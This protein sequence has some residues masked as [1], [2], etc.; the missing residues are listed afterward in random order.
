MIF[1]TKFFFE[2]LKKYE[3]NEKEWNWR[4]VKR[5]RGTGKG[6]KEMGLQEWAK[7]GG[8]KVQERGQDMRGRVQERGQEMRGGGYHHS[9]LRILP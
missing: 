8:W 3:L 6:S 2:R 4:G 9:S 5:R 7:R 1:Q